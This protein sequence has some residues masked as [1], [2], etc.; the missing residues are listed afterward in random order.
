MAALSPAPPS[1]WVLHDGKPGMASQALGLAEATGLPFSEKQLAIRRPWAWLPPQLWLA[2]L[3][4]ATDAGLPL[5]PPWPDLVIGCGRNTARPALAI[6]RA[7][8]GRT[9]AAQIQDPRV[10]RGEFDM[11]FVPEHDRLRGPRIL[12]TRGAIHRVTQGRLAAE[13]ARFPALEALARPIIGVLI[14]GSNR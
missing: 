11:L 13:R 5:A 9:L 7:S 8:F 3:G 4:A 12:V 10:G 2:P 1:V 14:G 6:R